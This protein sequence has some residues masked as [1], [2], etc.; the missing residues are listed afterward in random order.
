MFELKL[1]ITPNG[2]DIDQTNFYLKNLQNKIETLEKQNEYLFKSLASLVTLENKIDLIL[3]HLDIDFCVETDEIDEIIAEETVV[4]T[5]IQK[6]EVAAEESSV[7]AENEALDL[8]FL[9]NEIN[10][11]K[12]FLKD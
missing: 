7:T 5:K 12:T 3:K 1:D 2:Y 4:E 10:A 6:N 11:L 8:S 9:R